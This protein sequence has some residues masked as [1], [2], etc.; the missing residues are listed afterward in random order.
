MS[1]CLSTPVAPTWIRETLASIQFLNLIQSVGL[2]GWE[3]S[4]TQG[5]YLHRTT[6]TQN[7]RIHMHIHALSCTRT[8]D[9]SVQEDEDISRLRPRCRCD[10][11]NS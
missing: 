6:Q 4:L 8:H 5:C 1:V 7:K 3:I 2:F 9:P 11:Q 10:Q